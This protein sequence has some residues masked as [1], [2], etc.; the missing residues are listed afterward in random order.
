MKKCKTIFVISKT[1]ILLGILLLEVRFA[2]LRKLR[3]KIAQDNSAASASASAARTEL[4]AVQ[5]TTAE[6]S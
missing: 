2:K 3:S 6:G 1:N 5:N 4:A